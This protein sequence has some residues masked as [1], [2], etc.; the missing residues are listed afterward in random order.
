MSVEIKS[1]PISVQKIQKFKNE[2]K[3]I[4]MITAYD[5]STAKYVDEAGV[6]TI[7]VGD[8]AAMVMLGYENTLKITLD[9]MLTFTRA[10]SKG[11]KKALVVA[12]MPFMSYHSDKIEAIKNAGEFLKAG[13]TAVKIEGGSDYIVDVVKHMTQQ[14][15]PVVS[16][17]GFT[18]QFINTIG[19]YNIQVKS[20][21]TTLKI[22]EQAKKLQDAGAFLLVLEMVP[23]ESAD[24]ITKNLQIP[25]I[26]IGAGN[27][28][29]G[30]VL[31]VDDVLG[32]YGDFC[33]KF[34]R[35][36]ADL[37]SIITQSVK[38]YAEDVETGDFPTEKESFFLNED[39]VKKLENYVIEND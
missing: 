34:A 23:K 6:D 21:E 18:P 5:Y 8:S 9:E 36:Y 22:Y 11:A 39:E 31:V 10:V 12:D 24:F 15:I 35:K 13:A 17:L 26:G 32:R 14:G 27:G 3:K 37:K 1:K 7:L 30:Q 25:T 16:H 29:S 20:F 33:P 4:T 38:K 28:C 19:G 2:N